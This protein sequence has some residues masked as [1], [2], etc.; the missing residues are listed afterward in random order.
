MGGEALAITFHLF[1]EA[2]GGDAVEFREVFIQHDPLAAQ[3][4]NRLAH[5]QD[6]C[7][8]YLEC[9]SHAPAFNG[10]SPA[11]PVPKAWLW[12]TKAQAR[13]ARSKNSSPAHK[14]CT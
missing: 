11:A 2:F 12:A 13:L 1:I 5:V 9:G 4:I 10:R 7:H 6:L 3:D 8:T 14:F